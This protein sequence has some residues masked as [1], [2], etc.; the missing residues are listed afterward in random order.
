MQSEK[1]YLMSPQFDFFEQDDQM[2]ITTLELDALTEVYGDDGFDA[3]SSSSFENDSGQSSGVTWHFDSDSKQWQ[4]SGAPPPECPEPLVFSAPVDVNLASGIIYPGQ[5]RGGDYKPHGGFR[6]DDLGSNS[7]DVYAPID[8]NLFRASRHLESGELQHSL[9]FINDCGIMYKLDHLRQLT[10]KFEE[11]LNAIPMGEEGDS[12]T[13][14]V[15]PAVFVAKGDHIA[16]K[17]GFES[18][19]NVFLDFGVYDLRE[20]NG[21]YYD[22]DFRSMHPSIDEYGAYALCWIDY[23]D[24]EDKVIVQSLP[25]SGIEGNMSDYCK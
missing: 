23:L 17:V 5:I 1:G 10:G 15:S 13:T 21:V 14:E 20:T 2:L 7:V 9:F 16:T 25:A 12:R 18:S 4:A 6:F 3:T 19:M 22:S 11:I 24:E 8:A